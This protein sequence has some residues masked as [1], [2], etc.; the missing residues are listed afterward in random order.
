MF[1]SMYTLFPA[2]SALVFA[3]GCQTVD[4]YIAPFETSAEVLN[5]S[6]SPPFLVENTRTAN[7]LPGKN[8][9]HVDYLNALLGQACTPEKWTELIIKSLRQRSKSKHATS[10]DTSIYAID[11]DDLQRG[12]IVYFR[13]RK[14]VPT[15]GVIA[16]EIKGGTFLGVSLIRGKIREFRMNVNHRNQRRR[17]GKIVNSFMRTIDERDRTHGYLAGELALKFARPF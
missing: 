5:V 2:L 16:R 9:T 1:D 10:L 14:R 12:D 11:F 17:R 15:Y 6:S 7:Q 13:R 3:F 4:T 8:T